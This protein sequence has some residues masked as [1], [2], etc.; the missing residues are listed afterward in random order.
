ML[1]SGCAEERYI[2]LDG[3]KPKSNSQQQSICSPGKI[4]TWELVLHREQN[5]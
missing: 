4:K 5:N 3:D 2:E 1:H